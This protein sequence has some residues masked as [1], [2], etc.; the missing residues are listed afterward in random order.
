MK[1]RCILI[2]LLL[3]LWTS[4]VL[5]DS[6][7]SFPPVP[8]THALVSPVSIADPDLN[9]TRIFRALSELKQGRRKTPV[10]IA[11]IGDSNHTLDYAADTLRHL[12]DKRFG[13]A[14]HGFIAAA[15]PW[16]WYD[17][18]DIR[19]IPLKGWSS[20]AISKRSKNRFR[21]FGPGSVIGEGHRGSGVRFRPARRGLAAN[22]SLEGATVH[23]LCRPRGGR[24]G[25]YLDGQ[26]ALTIQTQCERPQWMSSELQTPSNIKRLDFRVERGKVSIFGVSFERSEPGVVIDNLS[27][28]SLNAWF[29][30]RLDET[31]FK[32]GLQSRNY[33]L[34]ILHTGTNMW[35][36]RKN[37]RDTTKTIHRV[38][39]ALGVDVSMLILTPGD[40]GRG[41]RRRG[42]RWRM[43]HCAQ[44]KRDIAAQ[45]R[46]ALWDYYR[47]MGGTKSISKW[48]KARLASLDYVHPK[49]GMNQVMFT[50][51]GHS[52]FEE[53]QGYLKTVG[54]CPSPAEPEP[55]PPHLPKTENK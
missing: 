10:R 8:E 34:V 40:A 11:L 39:D 45:T 36:P 20:R 48:V 53:Y 3:G 15:K 12:F 29:L 51:L 37:R 13:S 17:H 16:S 55:S 49:A 1:T 52:F 27:A 44:E 28:S 54:L 24:F 25:V 33:D 32:E 31:R 23:Y 5:G 9:L 47:A 46:V 2:S 21:G 43:K 41:R 50:S 14:G 18:A 4:P 19:V 7:C 35:S 30:G 42:F 26:K 6:I 22:R 38:R